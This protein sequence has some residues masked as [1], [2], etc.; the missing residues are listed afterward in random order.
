M[1]VF[2]RSLR[3]LLLLLFTFLLLTACSNTNDD[4]AVVEVEPPPSLQD[5]TAEASGDVT[6]GTANVEEV[7]VNVL[8]GAVE[9]TVSGTLPDGC[10]TID[11]INMERQADTFFVDITTVRPTDE[12]CTEAL[13]PF[14]ETVTLD[15]ADLQPG[16][17]TV[18]INSVAEQFQIG[19]GTADGDNV[20]TGLANVENVDVTVQESSIDVV[21]SGNLQ[22]GCTEIADVTTERQ[23]AGFVISITTARPADQICTEALVPFEETI[24]IDTGD[25]EPGAY[26]V[27][28][29][30][31]TEQFQVGDGAAPGQG[32]N[33]IAGL[34]N[35]ENIDVTVQESSLQV[36][37]SGNL[38]DGCT[39]IA[40]IT[41]ERQ[42][43]I[44]V[45]SITTAR[46][47]D[48]ICTQALVP[49]EETITIDTTNLQPG[50]YT[51]NVN[52]VR[53]QFQV[54][55]GG[56]P[57]G[58]DIVTGLANVENVN[59][60]TQDG[61]VEVIASGNL[62]DS[63]TEIA[64]VTTERRG[65]TFVI[66]ITTARPADQ[67]C[68][69]VLVPFEQTIRLD[70]AP[71]DP[72]AYT[73][74]V[75][76]VT[77]QFQ[78]GEGAPPSDGQRSVTIEPTT[79]A[80]GT[81]VTLR[82]TGFPPNTQVELGLGRWRS[83]Y[84]VVQTATTD[85]NGNLTTTVQ[86]PSFAEVNEQWVAVVVLDG[87]ETVSG[88]FE[89]TE[90]AAE[91]VTIMPNSGAPGTQV[92]VTARGFPAN[93]PL[94]FSVSAEGM[95]DQTIGA[96]VTDAEGTATIDYL[97]PQT[98]QAGQSYVFRASTD[99]IAAV[100]NPF[101]VFTPEDDGNG[102]LF[103]EAQIYLVELEGGEGDNAI[104]CG[105][106][107]QPITVSINPTIAPLTAA[108]NTMLSSDE[109]F[110]GQT[111]LYNALA[112]SD[113]R[114]KGIDI[115]N[116]VAEI[117]LTGDLQVGGICDAPRIEAQI[118]QTALQYSTIDQVRIFLEGQPLDQVLSGRG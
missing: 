117:N 38:Q 73:V 28:A 24:T 35:V 114:V 84:D 90:T 17:Y 40:D 89:V 6:T 16:I 76:G 104:G 106:R 44:F 42:E 75:N 18:N 31:V 56:A 57:G 109:E 20:I 47:A 116:R 33:V 55:D 1:H 22:D 115:T 82:A 111:G 88:I 78:L 98:A 37:V 71:L 2:R 23:A 11:E 64:D 27:D 86:I 15:T 92:Q 53:E 26:T 49:Y 61:I 9:V 30:G 108:L 83:E 8:D 100:S 110:Y 99:G 58:G 81:T 52:N 48:Q 5:G 13:V 97:V 59:V 41:R 94:Q 91:T 46:P 51:V 63:C 3:P 39:E 34:A 87:Q 60:M 66:S 112:Q 113:L 7:T 50:T 14:E 70:T 67:M 105:D 103:T 118:R 79:G 54:G 62:E 72:G 69:Q 45:I 25:L 107:L 102:G 21:V 32:D 95:Q 36:V 77:Q 93:T 74:D 65:D 101:N 80:P 4:G 12:V 68:A 43:D 85:A 10:T 19:E 96:A 29:N